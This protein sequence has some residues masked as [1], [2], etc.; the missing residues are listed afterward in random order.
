MWV[1][2]A[3][4][5]WLSC[6]QWEVEFSGRQLL[7]GSFSQFP[8]D[9]METPTLRW[10]PCERSL[11]VHCRREQKRR[12]LCEK[13]LRHPVAWKLLEPASSSVVYTY[14]H[15]PDNTRDQ[16]NWNF[17]PWKFTASL[18]YQRLGKSCGYQNK[19]K[20]TLFKKT[21]FELNKLI[22]IGRDFLLPY[23]QPSSVSLTP[24]WER[25]AKTLFDSVFFLG[26]I[27]DS[28]A[29]F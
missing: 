20:K 22:C 16:I 19:P 2:G 21:L 27:S 1:S 6:W 4:G 9:F 23:L 17:H 10:S 8:S 25:T 7:F 24:F 13:P 11:T 5:T 18:A 14:P 26:L 3:P 29:F 12:V 15:H 28:W